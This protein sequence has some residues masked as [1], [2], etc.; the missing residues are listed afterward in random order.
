MFAV[1]TAMR[2]YPMI[3]YISVGAVAI[4][5]GVDD[6]IGVVVGG[7]Y[8]VDGGGDSSSKI[9]GSEGVWSGFGDHACFC[10]GSRKLRWGC[11]GRFVMD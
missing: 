2:F 10:A 5:I 7:K 4:S 3:V 11:Q 1:G 8:Y 6:S 9:N